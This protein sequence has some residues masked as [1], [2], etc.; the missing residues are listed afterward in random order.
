[1]RRKLNQ[2]KNSF[3]KSQILTVPSIY[4]FENIVYVVTNN[5]LKN[6][7]NHNH[8][9]IHNIGP[10]QHNIQLYEKTPYLEQQ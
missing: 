8:N 7:N 5:L 10:I 6:I 1:M 9:K 2:V 4:I 3:F